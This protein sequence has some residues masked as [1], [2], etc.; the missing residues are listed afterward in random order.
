MVKS[1]AMSMARVRQ[2]PQARLHHGADSTWMFDD[3]EKRCTRTHASADK[4]D[5]I[6][7]A[8]D[9]YKCPAG[10]RAI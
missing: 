3:P 8:K 4:S 1:G 6:Y 2:K 5:F 10:E 9:E 7:I